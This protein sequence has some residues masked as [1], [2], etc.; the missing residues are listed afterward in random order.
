MVRLFVIRCPKCTKSFEV[1]YQDLRH[2]D[3][4]LHCPYCDHWFLQTESEEIDDRW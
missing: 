1:H 3:I 2:T 4:K